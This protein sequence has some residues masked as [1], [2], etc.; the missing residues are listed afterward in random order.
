[1][2]D[3][4]NP[5]L[6]V[7]CAAIQVTI[8][9]LTEIIPVGLPISEPSQ[10][11]QSSSS[12]PQ[13]QASKAAPCKVEQVSDEINPALPAACASVQVTVSP[14]IKII[15]SGLPI[16]EPSQISQSG[17]SSPGTHLQA[18]KQLLAQQSRFPAR[19]IQCGL[20]PSLRDRLPQR[21]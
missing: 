12:T 15:P 9:P 1:V 13:L 20:Q 19:S 6:P 4:I 14:L 21:R 8:R 17:L 2:S 11:S 10:M 5:A 3:E 16:A 18:L 7:A